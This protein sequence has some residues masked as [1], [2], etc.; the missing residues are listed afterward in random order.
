MNEARTQGLI[1][2]ENKSKSIFFN[3][4]VTV[5]MESLIIEYSQT[6][7]KISDRY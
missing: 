4:Q 2:S 5:K 6:N 7:S 1:L 3:A